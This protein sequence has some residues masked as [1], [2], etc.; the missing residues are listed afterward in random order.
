MDPTLILLALGAAV[1]TALALVLTQFGLRSLDPLTGASISIPTTALLLLSIAPLTVDFHNWNGGSVTIFAMAGVI[2]P[3]AVT[4]LTF[5]SN[6]QIGPTLTGALG[7]LSPLFSVGLAIVLV[8]EVPTW[9]QLAGACVIFVGAI[10]LLSGRTIEHHA[11]ALWIFGLPIAAAFLRGLVQ[12]VVKIG[13][14]TWPNPFAAATIGYIISALIVTAIRLTIAKPHRPMERSHALWFVA[15]GACN[16]AANLALYAAL[17]R[18]P[19]AI[20]APLVA[21]YPLATL[22]LERFLLGK[23]GAFGHARIFGVLAMVAG[24]VFLLL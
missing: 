13:L 15:V 17:A 18:G 20:V 10:I 9:L 5:V 14:L 24:V 19:V 6:R 11:V 8:G 7:N 12:P 2:F 3:V 22:G 1:L 4:V 21:V 16:G 23:Q